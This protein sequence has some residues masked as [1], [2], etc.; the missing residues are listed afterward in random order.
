MPGKGVF[1]RARVSALTRGWGAAVL[2][3]GVDSAMG[4]LGQHRA[5]GRFPGTPSHPS[6]RGRLASWAS[7]GEVDT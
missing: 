2:N 3:L 6:A 5:A 7:G 4:A 1:E